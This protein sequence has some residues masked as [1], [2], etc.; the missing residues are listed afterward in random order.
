[1]QGIKNKIAYIAILITVF[2][3]SYL[4]MDAVYENSIDISV[5]ETEVKI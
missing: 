2:T 1:M 3:L 4:I 5:I